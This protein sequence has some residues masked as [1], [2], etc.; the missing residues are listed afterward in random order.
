MRQR[1]TSS[2]GKSTR[3]V[4][5]RFGPLPLPVFS[6]RPREDVVMVLRQFASRS[7]RP[8]SGLG[9]TLI[10]LL[11]VIAII[12]ILVA[13]LL[14]AVQQV[15]EAARKTQCQDHMHNI[16]IALHNY[17]DTF[18]MFPEGACGPGY[19]NQPWEWNTGLLSAQVALLPYNEQKPL[20]DQLPMNGTVYLPPWNAGAPQFGGWQQDISYLHCPSDVNLTN[21]DGRGH[22]NYKTC[23][24]HKVQNGNIQD[25]HWNRTTGV[26]SFNNP[27]SIQ[28]ILD[29]T[30]N[31]ILIG[32]MCVGNEGD[33]SD[34][35]GNVAWNV[36]GSFNNNAALC[37]AKAQNGKYIGAV[38]NSTVNDWWAAPGIRW[39]EGRI[40]Y[41]GFTTIL[42]PNSPS[43][44][45]ATDGDWGI[46]SASS[47]HP[48]GAQVLM[49]DDQVRFVSEN[50]DAGNPG[51]DPAS[52]Q[53]VYGVWGAI[54]TRQSGETY[55]KF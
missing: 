10:E 1:G 20:Y 12:A 38:R 48:G 44:A 27:T 7:R 15:R 14:P 4:T 49:G 32:E 2:S 45:P 22:K 19:S 16:G 17:H 39:C 8:V 47:R 53:Q 21:Y 3:K 34:V 31:T 11:V 13:L 9:F 29:G 35:R 6:I 40:Y 23:W 28:E 30:S 37:K 50:I 24:G 46:Y 41:E 26:F 55:T 42:P 18:Q 5:L 52:A 54:G 43:C 51:A 25:N 33:P 36:G